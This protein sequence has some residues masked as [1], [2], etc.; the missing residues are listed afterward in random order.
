MIF[1]ITSLLVVAVLNLLNPWILRPQIHFFVE[2]LCRFKFSS[3][4]WN[5]ALPALG[6]PESMD[7]WWAEH[8]I[9]EKASHDA[10]S[11]GWWNLGNFNAYQRH[12][13]VDATGMLKTY[14]PLCAWG[15]IMPSSH[16]YGCFSNRSW[17]SL[18]SSASKDS[19]GLISRWA[20]V[21]THVFCCVVN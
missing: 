21:D 3:Y 8:Y 16:T 14:V 4:L 11:I 1:S 19:E 10:L 15:L 20:D 5:R 17:V 9:A 13:R 18:C 2:I 6:C 7:C 12:C